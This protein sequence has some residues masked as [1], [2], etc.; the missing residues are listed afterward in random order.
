MT[1]AALKL[2]SQRL[3]HG[4]AGMFKMGFSL[5][6]LR[7]TFRAIGL[8]GARMKLCDG[9]ALVALALV[10]GGCSTD[11]RVNHA[12]SDAGA[13][14]EHDAGDAGDAASSACDGDHEVS[15]AADLAPL[16]GCRVID[17]QLVIHAADLSD[18]RLP[19]LEKVAGQLS[20][21]DMPLLTHL[22]LPVL[23]EVDGDLTVL[24]DTALT[25]PPPIFWTA[26]MRQYASRKDEQEATNQASAVFV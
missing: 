10:F 20:I 23:S 6:Q 1:S 19:L 11:A 3:T 24:N 17:G 13:A 21:A 14:V 4:Q 25:D 22:E 7:V 8:G 2:T 9:F 15:A 16:A 18:L 12:G 26:L 5:S